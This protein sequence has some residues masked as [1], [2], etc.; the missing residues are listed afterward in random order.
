MRIVSPA[1]FPK[2]QT[3]TKSHPHQSIFFDKTSYQD[4]VDLQKHIP[5]LS[6]MQLKKKLFNNR[7]QNKPDDLKGLVR[8]AAGD[9]KE[10]TQLVMQLQRYRTQF[11]DMKNLIQ[12]QQSSSAMKPGGAGA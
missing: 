10:I 2:V 8:G 1:H 4:P 6:S 5:E 12:K 7:L 3:Q 11:S 9:I